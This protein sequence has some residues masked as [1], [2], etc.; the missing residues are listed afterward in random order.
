MKLTQIN[1]NWRFT[2]P[3]E[4]LDDQTPAWFDVDFDDVTWNEAA[5][6]FAD[7]DYSALILDAEPLAYWP[8]DLSDILNPLQERRAFLHS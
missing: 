5:S 8:L 2:Q 1:T 4:G 6:P 7:I 3:L